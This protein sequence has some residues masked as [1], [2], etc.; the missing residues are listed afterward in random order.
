MKKGKEKR[1]SN[2]K[3]KLKKKSRFPNEKGEK[4]KHS[5]KQQERPLI[6]ELETFGQLVIYFIV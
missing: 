3:G 5:N 4:D 2:E 1:N 6:H